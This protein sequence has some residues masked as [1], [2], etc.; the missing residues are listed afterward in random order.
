MD[1]AVKLIA[2][3]QN[4]HCIDHGLHGARGVAGDTG[5]EKEAGNFAFLDHLG[6]GA[7]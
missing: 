7:G 1:I 5:G 4:V 2:P 6:E 3:A